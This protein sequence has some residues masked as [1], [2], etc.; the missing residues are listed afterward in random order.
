MLDKSVGFPGE[1]EQTGVE[2][3][4]SNQTKEKKRGSNLF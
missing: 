3:M 1:S 4:Q 2:N